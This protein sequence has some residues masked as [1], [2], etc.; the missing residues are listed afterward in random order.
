L[1]FTYQIFDRLLTA[2]RDLTIS[3]GLAERWEISDDQLS[4]TLFL[5]QGV[6]Y[7][8][9]TPFDAESVAWNIN[10]HKTHP[11]S[12]LTSALE[13][14][15][16]VE[17]VDTH[18]VR[19]VLSSPFSPLLAQLASNA[20]MMVS[21]N[22]AEAQGDAFGSAPHMG[23]SGPFIITEQVPN[24]H[25]TL[26]RNPNWWGTEAG[27]QLPYLDELVV[28]VFPD[29]SV[30]FTN[31]RSGDSHV[32][33]DLDR[34][35]LVIAR[36]DGSLVVSSTPSTTFVGM[37]A[38]HQEGK[39]FADSRY[40]K[41]VSMAIDRAEIATVAFQDTAK[42]GYGPITPSHGLAY[43]PAFE[44]YKV[45]DPEGAKAL[46]EEVGQGPLTFELLYVSGDPATLQI[47]QLI[48]AQLARADITMNL[49]GLPSAQWTDEFVAGNYEMTWSGIG[50]GNID[51]EVRIRDFCHSTGRLNTGKY[52]NPEVDQLLD[53]QR[54]TFDL[55]ERRTLLRRAEEIAT[56]DDPSHVW[57]AFPDVFVV[58][59]AQVHGLAAHPVQRPTF[60]TT[61]IA[62]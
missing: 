26:A 62:P 50:T 32:I 10:R 61:W 40:V 45:A 2:N 38:G 53:Q 20:G 39:P 49:R 47:V 19:L 30:R 22:E 3:P 12:V 37:F 33:Y 1:F 29:S 34:A 15:A 8:D 57:V 14:I 31:V 54:E 9:G 52:S 17:I 56:V 24:D 25:V 55:D 36:D 60:E 4:V 59:K 18:T 27:I 16:S 58:H 23:G 7:Q 28:R 44:P 5:R 43:D 41:A 46:I 35:D 13:P 51:P 11:S 21:K 6:A 42:P 48:Q